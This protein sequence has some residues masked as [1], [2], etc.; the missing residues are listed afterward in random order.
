MDKAARVRWAV[1]LSCLAATI[2]AIFLPQGPVAGRA[3]PAPAPRVATTLPSNVATFAEASEPEPADVPD[4]D[5][6]APR[7]WQAPPPP[8]PVAYSAPAPVA[9]LDLTPPGPPP[10][11]FRFVG[12]MSDGAELLVYLARGEQA[13]AARPGEVLDGTYKVAAIGPAQI[14]FEHIPTGAKQSLA[15]PVSEQ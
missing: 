11:P 14:E 5:P 7:G 2:G 3:A 13:Y 15:F 10:L 12:R 1:L 6:F 8:A 4:G 9:T